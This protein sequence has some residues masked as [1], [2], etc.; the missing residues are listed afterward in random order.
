[1]T[2]ATNMLYFKYLS[3]FYE[4]KKI[5]LVYDKAPS[6]CSKA[7]KDYTKSWNDNLNNTCT[8]VIEFVDRCLT[9]VYQLSDVMYNK[10]F[11]ALI[12]TRYNESIPTE[13][14]MVILILEISIK[15]QEMI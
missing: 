6:H 3:N 7:V 15:C 11:K 14:L 8:F 1:M 12:Q 5:V 10:L 9:S 4:G 13:L 2:S